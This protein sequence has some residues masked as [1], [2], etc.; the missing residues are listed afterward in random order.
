MLV[1]GAM[2]DKDIDGMLAALAPAAREIIVTQVEGARAATLDAL[3]TAAR[4]HFTD[5]AACAPS[6]IRV[7]R[8][9]RHWRPGRWHVSPGRFS[10]SAASSRTWMA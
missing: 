4:A 8:S 2:A 9:T 6:R 5:R 1:F 10:C 7:T 3:A